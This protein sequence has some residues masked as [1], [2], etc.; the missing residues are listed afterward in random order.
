MRFNN[1]ISKH[2]FWFCFCIDF[3]LVIFFRYQVNFRWCNEQKSKCIYLSQKIEV[4]SFCVCINFD[5][6]LKCARYLFYFCY[7]GWSLITTHIQAD[8]KSV[9]KKSPSNSSWISKINSCCISCWH[10]LC[11]YTWMI[12]LRMKF[13]WC[14]NAF[15]CKIIRLYLKVI[16]IYLH[17]V[18]LVVSVVI[19]NLSTLMSLKTSKAFMLRIRS[20]TT[21][22]LTAPKKHQQRQQKPANVDHGQ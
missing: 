12:S 11:D 17:L 18:S 21:T 3:I 9:H 22:A 20:T 4:F 7:T 8:V 19:E 2:K 13:V 14:A 6:Q 10:T 5:F 1:T 16:I 15:A